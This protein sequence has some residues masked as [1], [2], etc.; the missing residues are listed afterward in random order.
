MTTMAMTRF[1]YRSVDAS[2]RASRGTIQAADRRAAVDQ[3]LQRGLTPLSVKEEGAKRALGA[4][5]AGGL[6]RAERL[7]FVRDLANLVAAGFALEPALGLVGDQMQR[8]AAATLVGRFAPG[9]GPVTA[10]RPP[11]PRKG[12]RSRRNSLA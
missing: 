3:L 6:K 5:R 7:S 11:W 9:C 8:P 4:G 10:W 12:P 2:G 1:S